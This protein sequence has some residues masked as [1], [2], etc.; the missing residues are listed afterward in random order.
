MIRDVHIETAIAEGVLTAEQAA[1]LRAIAGRAAVATEPVSI[2]A[3]PDDERFRLI[4]G[5]NDVFVTI[6]VLLLISALVALSNAMGF[7][8]GFTAIAVAAAWG[9]SEIFARRMRLAL[10]SI[11]LALMFAGAGA[12]VFSTIGGLVL[13]QSGVDINASGEGNHAILA[14]LLGFGGAIA[15]VLHERRFHVPIDGAILAGAIVCAVYAALQL[16]LPDLVSNAGTLLFGVFG[17]AIFAV[18]VRVDAGDPERLTRRSDIAFWLHLLA[19]P[20]IVHAVIPLL[21]GPGASMSV[22][23]ALGILGI[24]T[25]LGLLAIV[26]DRRALLVSGLSYAGIAIAYLLSESPAKDMSL[27][28]TLLGLAV[29]V[30]GL[31]VGWRRLR[32]AV[33]PILPLGDFRR[34]VPPT[35]RTSTALPDQSLGTSPPIIRP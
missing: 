6:G 2:Q 20:M 22:A 29:L 7:M 27:S 14:M 9:L 15:A 3:D 30:L 18:A 35:V 4:G 34:H 17:L 21:M 31:S 28:L 26:I 24:F 32:A 12:G 10:P 16:V 8:L 23:Q 19:A 13:L 1:R 5:F 25:L 11:V 33:V